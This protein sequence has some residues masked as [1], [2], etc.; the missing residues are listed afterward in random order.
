MANQ[1]LTDKTSL[2]EFADGDLI[3]VVDVSDTTGSAQGTSK[4]SAWSLFKSTLKTYFDGFYQ[5]T[6][7]F[8]PENVANKE[9]T[10]IDTDTTKYPTVNL[11]KTGLD[12]KQD[13][14]VSGTN[15]KTINSTSVLG[16][17]DITIS[18]GSS[19]FN[20]ITSGTN[21][22]AAMVV[23]S[24][25]SLEVSGTGAIGATSLNG[26][27]SSASTATTQTQAD[28]STKVATTAYVDAGLGTKQD[29][30]NL[31]DDISTLSGNG[32]IVRVNANTAA[33][34]SIVAGSSKIAITNGSGASGNPSIDIG[35]LVKGDVG[36]GDVDNTSDLNKSISTATQTA[37]DLKAPLASPAFTGTV[38]GISIPFTVAL[39]DETTAITTG[40]AKI[41]FRT[42]YA[43]TLTEVRASLSTA[44]S[45]G[46]PTF[47]INENGTSILSTKLT[48]DANEK[49][50]TT[51]TTP[52]V[53]SDSALADDAE[54][55]IDIDVAGTEAKG[56]KITMYLTRV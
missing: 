54:I 19:A 44:S 15:I 48:I 55:T 9:N 56:A 21:T 6:L 17:G 49:T 7:G 16:S 10:T 13:T 38:K 23:G 50:S 36:L 34:R 25:S 53:I 27:I 22:A 42:P 47:D 43:C 3:H 41:T 52:V 2:T 18:A 28:N 30:D 14:L 1:K 31:L 8:T 35:T 24:G 46:L 40:T 4:K 33:S 12:L 11:L 32:I 29:Q 26:T 5:T 51:A 45:S 20:E 39:S 37:L